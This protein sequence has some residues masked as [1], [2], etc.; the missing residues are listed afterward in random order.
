MNFNPRES[1]TDAGKGSRPQKTGGGDTNFNLFY[2]S[3]ECMYVCMYVCMYSLY[4]YN[5][6]NVYTCI[7][8]YIYMNIYIKRIVYIHIYI[9][10]CVYIYI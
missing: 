7:N 3:G 2:D 9:Y 6:V 8:A 10:K 1:R 4:I 5:Y